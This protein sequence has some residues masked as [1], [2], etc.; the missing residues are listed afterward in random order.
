MAWIERPDYEDDHLCNTVGF[1]NSVWV[2]QEATRDQVKWSMHIYSPIQP[3][4]EP[5][6]ARTQKFYCYL[7]IGTHVALA[8]LQLLR[9]ALVSLGTENPLL[10]QVHF[11]LSEDEEWGY[12]TWVRVLGGYALGT[13]PYAFFGPEG[14]I[15]GFFLEHDWYVTG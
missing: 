1:V 11:Q 8:Q 3:Y 7:D 15:D 2:D 9:D 13:S 6:V 10:T 12:V 5:I 14:G 4:G